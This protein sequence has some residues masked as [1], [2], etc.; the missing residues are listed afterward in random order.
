MISRATVL[1]SSHKA[2]VEKYTSDA[3]YRCSSKLSQDD[4]GHTDL[5]LWMFSEPVP[6]ATQENGHGNEKKHRHISLDIDSKVANFLAVR[7]SCNSFRLTT[8]FY[9]YEKKKKMQSLP[10][11]GHYR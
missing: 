11:D 7:K 9:C 1:K 10:L 6:K 3:A 8:R 5:N 2:R 4:H